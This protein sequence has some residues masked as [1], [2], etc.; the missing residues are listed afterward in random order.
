M[1]QPDDEFIETIVIL[2]KHNNKN[3]ND[4]AREA[5]QRFDNYV[6]DRNKVVKGVYPT[7]K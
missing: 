2:T 1:E 4:K 5:K 3:S 7:Y 6:L